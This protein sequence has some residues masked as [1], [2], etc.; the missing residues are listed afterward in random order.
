MGEDE[1]HGEGQ[2]QH[3]DDSQKPTK[4]SVSTV[5]AEKAK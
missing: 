2:N 1:I 3:N 5:L 4:S